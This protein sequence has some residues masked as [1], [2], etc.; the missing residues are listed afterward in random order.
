MNVK[1]YLEKSFRGIKNDDDRLPPVH[2]DKEV[3]V[4][5]GSTG[6]LLLAD[7]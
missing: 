2:R 7:A 3:A 4:S 6:A 1:C 5:E